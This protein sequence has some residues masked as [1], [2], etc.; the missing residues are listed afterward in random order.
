MGGRAADLMDKS[1]SSTTR[2]REG[3]CKSM[4]SQ[5][6]SVDTISPMTCNNKIIIRPLATGG[7][8]HL[9]VWANREEGQSDS[10]WPTF[11]LYLGNGRHAHCY[12]GVCAHCCVCVCERWIQIRRECKGCVCI[13]V[14]V[15]TTAGIS[16]AMLSLLI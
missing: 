8:G 12:Q 6:I 15:Y 13:C 14:C 7:E 4:D 1:M 5:F 3:Y 16:H 9:A 2:G 11:L 10:Q